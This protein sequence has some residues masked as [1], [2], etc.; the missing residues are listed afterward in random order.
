LAKKFGLE[1]I[2][3]DHRKCGRS[4]RKPNQP[5]VLM[6]F[7]GMDELQGLHRGENEKGIEPQRLKQTIL[8][9][10]MGFGLIQ[11]IKES[12]KQMHAA[13]PKGLRS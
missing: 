3:L 12:V 8:L 1:V 6:N 4:R 7:P 13:G 11:T 2:S 5:S 9:V 10:V